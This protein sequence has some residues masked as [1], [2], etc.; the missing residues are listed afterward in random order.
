MS[1]FRAKL[2]ARIVGERKSIRSYINLY[3]KNLG[4]KTSDTFFFEPSKIQI[5]QRAIDVSTFGAISP[6][7]CGQ[8]WKMNLCGIGNFVEPELIKLDVPSDH[9][10]KS[11]G[12]RRKGSSHQIET[13]R[14]E[15]SSKDRRSMS[16]G[17]SSSRQPERSSSYL[18]PISKDDIQGTKSRQIRSLEAGF[19]LVSVRFLY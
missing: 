12:S 13:G 17:R 3:W 6:Y 1:H 14:H 10:R 15:R 4:Q 19:N 8:L 18:N 5:K 16:K 9:F 2:F 7:S 11:S